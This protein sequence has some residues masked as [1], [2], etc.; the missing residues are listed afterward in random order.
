MTFFGEFK[1][2]VL[3][4]LFTN[5]KSP[6]AYAS[7]RRLYKQ[8]NQILPSITY[9]DAKK[10]LQSTQSRTG[11]KQIVRKYK[12]RK[13]IVKG[14]NHQWQA[15]LIEMQH[16]KHKNNGKRYI[17]AVIDCFSRKAYARAL[18]DKTSGETLEKFKE[19]LIESGT[20]PKIIQFD[21]GGEFKRDFRNFLE[22]KKIKYFSTASDDKAAI[23]ERWNRT[24]KDTLYEYF[25][26]QNTE[27]YVDVLQDFVKA[28]NN[29]EHRMIGMKPNDVNKSN[30]KSLWDKQYKNHIYSKNPKF[31]FKVGDKVKLVKY[32]KT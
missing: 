32:R 30:E 7:T 4:T 8:A 24:I 1:A 15:D 11:H 20:Q 28:Y 21:D 17:L 16:M 18:K 3:H 25:T 31:R 14:I 5:T 26:A 22:Q 10:Y 12:K 29:S 13:T 2:H 27:R 6:V 19:I 23:V 9:N